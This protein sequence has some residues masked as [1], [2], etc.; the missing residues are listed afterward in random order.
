MPHPLYSHLLAPLDLGFTVLKNRVLMGSMHTGLEELPDGHHRLAAF[1]AERAA[2][3]A[4]LIVTGGIAPNDA[5]RVADHS[6]AQLTTMAEAKPHQTITEAVHQRGGKICLQILHTGRYAFHKKLVAPSPIQAPINIF[7]PSMLS[8][9]EI[10]TQIEDFV[11]CAGLAQAAGYD[12]VEIMGSE[13]YLINQ[14]IVRHTNHR[15]DKWG[16]AYENRIRFA[17]EIVERTR[18]ATGP[19][20]II[21]FRLSLL[22]LIENGSTWDEIVLLAHALE[23]AGVTLLNSGIGWHE[24]RIPTIAAMVPRAAFSWTTA[25]LKKEVSVPVITSNRINTPE[26]AEKV[27]TDQE[28]DM[29]SMAR[30]MLAD[31]E[32]VSKAATGRAYLINTCI[33]CNQA[34]LDHIF[35]GRTATCLVNPRAGRETELNFVPTDHPR[36]IAVVGSGPAGLSCAVTAAQRGHRVVLY[37]KN[38]DIGGQ[39]N[40]AVQIPGKEEFEETLRY[41]RQQIALLGVTVHLDTRAEA[42]QLVRNRFDV[43]VVA[44][45]I[46]PRQPAIPGI[47]HPSVLSYIDVLW[48]KKPVGRKV[49]I[50]GAGGIGFDTAVYLTHGD[51]RSTTDRGTYLREWGIDPH[52]VHPGGLDPEGPRPSKSSRD[53]Y[54]LQR[55]G[56][57]VGAGLSKTTGWIHRIQLKQRA[58]TMLNAVAYERIDDQG[59]HITRQEKKMVLGVD[60]VVI[61]AGQEPER[62]LAEALADSGLPVHIIGGADVAVELDAKRAIDQGARLA[63]QL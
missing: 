8:G 47:D 30:P 34:C 48:H 39:L 17:L 44:S 43:V 41:Y 35:T 50:I 52:L 20:F 26:V 5:G 7:K 16:G 31:S 58:V 32:F 37:E 29:V 33:A 21:I 25:K 14:F 6:T 51:S 40:I 38:S 46:T 55:K 19:A 13:G 2:G 54:L 24:A 53:I 3:G 59:L 1:Y 18:R 63:A 27:L 12:G 36:R 10:E 61:C 42:E 49:A 22:D 28:A 23:S 11:R 15:T 4:A 62:Q 9:E 57:K 45:G 60:N 56:S